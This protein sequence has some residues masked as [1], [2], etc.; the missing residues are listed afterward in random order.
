MP[1]AAPT[2][3]P[4]APRTKVALIGAGHWHVPLYLQRLAGP[5]IEVVAVSDPDAAC[6]RRVAAR[7]GCPAFASDAEALA[8][9]P[10]DL[11]LLFGRHSDLAALGAQCVAHRIPFVIEKP[12]GLNAEEVGALRREAEAAG[13]YAAV[14]FVFRLSDLRHAIEIKEGR[15]PARFHHLAFRFVVGPPERYIR[16]G[17]GWMLDRAIAGGGSTINVG[18]HF[19]DLFR[20]LTGSPIRSVCAI[21]SNRG[22]RLA[23]EDHSMLLMTA[24]DGTTGIIETG[25]SY[26]STKDDQREFSFSLSSDAAYYRSAPDMLLVRPR[27]PEPRTRN[28]PVRL[29][30][31]IYYPLFFDRV[32]ADLASGAAPVAGLADAEAM[33]RVVDAAYDSARDGGRPVEVSG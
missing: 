31:D 4:P 12:C 25:Y 15:L 18:S 22:H 19:I 29:D 10:V 28:V 1:D 33:M 17:S 14:P 20:L 23:V 3:R 13:V 9:G 8:A 24:E 11:A 7:Y 26:P 5:D 21:M 32:L 30:T 27:V 6:A 16:A 2:A